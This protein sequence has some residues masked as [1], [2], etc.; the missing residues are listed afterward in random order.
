MSTEEAKR[1]TVI[2]Q[3]IAKQITQRCAAELIDLITQLYRE[4]YRDSNFSHFT[5]K[6]QDIHQ[7]TVSRPTVSSMLTSAGFTSSR[8]HASE[9]WYKWMPIGLKKACGLLTQAVKYLLYYY[10]FLSG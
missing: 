9:N 5:D 6:L 4:Q 7:L 2:K 3:V 10:L 8:K 1:L